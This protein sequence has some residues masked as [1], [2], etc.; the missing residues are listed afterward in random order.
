MGEVDNISRSI[1]D[2]TIQILDKKGVSNT[3]IAAAI[4]LVAALAKSI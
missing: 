4:K 2:A 3:V 1:V